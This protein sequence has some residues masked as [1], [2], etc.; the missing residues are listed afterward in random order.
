M[1]TFGSRIEP[2]LVHISHLSIL[3]E[4]DNI[5]CCG[6]VLGC[7]QTWCQMLMALLAKC[8]A[9]LSAPYSSAPPRQLPLPNLPWMK[10]R[11][12]AAKDFAPGQGVEPGLSDPKPS[13]T[14]AMPIASMA[15]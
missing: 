15:R 12:R 11:L 3:S 8:Q 10:L 5:L 13:N 2:W 1:S 4:H 7:Q 9:Q 14:A 6:F